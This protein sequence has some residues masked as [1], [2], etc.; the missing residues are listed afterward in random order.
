MYRLELR[1]NETRSHEQRKGILLQME[2]RFELAHAVQ[3]IFRWGRHVSGIA[4]A[5]S[6]NPVLASSK[7]TGLCM[8]AAPF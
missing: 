5:C 4:R 1:V 6:S 2:E 7:L 3:H 8:T